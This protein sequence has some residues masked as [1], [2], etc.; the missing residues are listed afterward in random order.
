MN[1]ACHLSFALVATVELACLRCLLWCLNWPLLFQWTTSERMKSESI[2][3]LAETASLEWVFSESK[4]DLDRKVAAKARFAPINSCNTNDRKRL[5]LRLK[6]RER[7]KV[8]VACKFY[9]QPLFTPAIICECAS[10]PTKPLCLISF[11]AA[12]RKRSLFH[13]TSTFI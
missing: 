5:R 7:E 6:E 12:A 11:A 13:N 2:S 1:T 10:L 4:E 8:R 9:S 3:C